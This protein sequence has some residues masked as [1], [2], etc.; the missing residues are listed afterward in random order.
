[1]KPLLTRFSHAIAAGLFCAGLTGAVASAS[2]GQSTASSAVAREIPKLVWAHY[3]GWGF[4]FPRSFDAPELGWR[5]LDDRSLLGKWVGPEAG[6]GSIERIQIAS[7]M[8]HGIDGFT[9][10]LS[11]LASYTGR[12]ARFYRAAEGLPFHISLCVDG[13]Q[14]QSIDAAV[15]RMADFLKAYG[16][17]PNNYF[18]DGKPVVFIYNPGRPPEDCREIV[19]RLRAQGLEAYWLIQPQREGT[20]WENRERLDEWLTIFDGFYDFGINGFSQDQMKL[21]LTN[22]R[23]ALARAGD[24]PG[25]GGAAVPR[26]LSAGIT[27]GYIGSHNA[28]YRPFFG[29]RS[30]RDNWEAALATGADWVCLTTWN[31]YTESTHFE[32]SVWGRDTLLRINREYVRRWRG[33]AAPARPEQVFVAYKSEV[34]LGDDWTFEVQS[35]PYTTAAVDAPSVV[36]VRVTDL[37]GEA[38]EAFPPVSLPVDAQHVVTHRLTRPG[39][40]TPR[41]LRVWTS[42]APADADESALGWSE[43]YPVVVR[44][45]IMRDM[46]TLRLALDDILPTPVQAR[47]AGVA[48]RDGSGPTLLVRFERHSWVGTVDLLRNGRMVETRE[49]ARHGQGPL[50]LSFALDRAADMSFGIPDN[51]YVV[52]FSRADGRLAFS[53]PFALKAVGAATTGPTAY[54]VILRE[55]DFD[56]AWGAGSAA[57]GGMRAANLSASEVYGFNFPMDDEKP[58]RLRD[59]FGWNIV[60]LGGGGRWGGITPEAVPVPRSENAVS[61]PGGVRRYLGFDGRNT[62]VLL[63]IG[64]S[65]HDTFTLE[66]RLRPLE[67]EEAGYVFSDQNEALGLGV[68]SGGQI[69]AQRGR[70]RVQSSAPLPAG[71]WSHVAAVYDGRT[72]S[73]YV[74]GRLAGQSPAA[75]SVSPINSVPVIG[76]RHQEH[77]RF[78]NY[79]RGD[80]AGLSVVARPLEPREFL[81]R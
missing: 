67:H 9:V 27:Q 78:S 61:L 26:L 7:A 34:R 28:F 44:P 75:P 41:V 18:I 52:R 65:P 17:H 42:V 2:S 77:L 66:A 21:R 35:F 70:T 3:V 1:M 51:L 39:F 16:R 36:R 4:D 55:G 47:L 74:D 14:G 25:A 15:E 11:G 68:L 8:R 56:E 63:Q 10:D 57:S 30:L 31:D 37:A 49:I 79:Y 54:E 58:R 62:R 24:I 43:L 60:S 12:M 50:D 53:A 19:V 6:S 72:L 33:E 76:C 38:V 22:G 13:W 59:T 23:E 45:G 71:R 46:K 20:L 5:R 48:G 29:T 73:L 69:F 81:L 40:D 32:P 80:M 64:A